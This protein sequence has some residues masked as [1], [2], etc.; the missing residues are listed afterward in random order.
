MTL[1]KSFQNE[2][3]SHGITGTVKMHIGRAYPDLMNCPD[4]VDNMIMYF[5][6]IKALFFITELDCN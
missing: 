2:T 6:V 4:Y 5:L 3:P 1:F